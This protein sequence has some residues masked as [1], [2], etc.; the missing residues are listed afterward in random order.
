MI[1]ATPLPDEFCRGHIGRLRSINGW[2]DYATTIQFLRSRDVDEAAT[3]AHT[4]VVEA[5]ALA[6]G[7][8]LDDYVRL[9][10]MLPFRSFV[11]ASTS[12][13]QPWGAKRL[14]LLGAVST[15][16]ASLFCP[17]CVETDLATRRY[18]YWR[19]AHQL[20][21]MDTCPTHQTRLMFVDGWQAFDRRPD[22]WLSNNL[23]K[24]RPP[25]GDPKCPFV[26]RFQR[27]ALR[28]LNNEIPSDTKSF[29]DAL[30]ARVREQ[31]P[32]TKDRR[33]VVKLTELASQLIDHEWMSDVFPTWKDNHTHRRYDPINVALL[34]KKFATTEAYCLAVSI[35]FEN[36]DDAVRPSSVR[37][38]ASTRPEGTSLHYIRLN[39]QISAMANER[40]ETAQDLRSH[41]IRI[42]AWILRHPSGQP[43]LRAL[44]RFESGEDLQEAADGEGVDMELVLNIL[45]L[46]LSDL[47]ASKTSSKAQTTMESETYAHMYNQPLKGTVGSSLARATKDESPP[48]TAPTRRARETLLAAIP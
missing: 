21:G 44:R 32:P 18:S 29:R 27:F 17:H 2:R 20:P 48:G 43:A 19:R 30:Y 42:R 41:L 47:P 40:G 6:S 33:E 3:D 24:T 16:S 1:I 34:P 46:Y 22:Y 35:L 26:S 9:H 11:R 8:T 13:E 25:F 4:S 14:R 10:T 39:G 7:L 45:R 5:I 15:R 38:S 37:A 36:L 23:S 31:N 12:E 28:I